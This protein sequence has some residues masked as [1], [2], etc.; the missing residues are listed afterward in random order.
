MLEANRK[1]GVQ[2]TRGQRKAYGVRLHA[3]GMS[4]NCSNDRFLLFSINMKKIDPRVARTRK[5]LHHAL[6]CLG[7]KRGYENLTVRAVT[8]YAGV[9]HVTFYRHYK[10][11]DDLLLE[12]VKTSLADLIGLIRKQDTV[13][14]EM[15]ATFTYIK[16]HQ[17]QFHAFIEL[18]LTHPARDLFKE[19]MGNFIVERYEAQDPTRVPLAVT[20]NHLLE[21][22][23]DM[24]RW[25]LNYIDD[26]TPQQVAVMHIDLIVKAAESTTVVLREDWLEQHPTR[27]SDRGVPA[28][29]PNPDTLN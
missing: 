8:A 14:D 9:S 2:Y 15:M 18:P 21:S 11:L 10:S 7:P 24:L 26:Y 29:E 5:A 3:R 17:Q 12:I 19:E 27:Q 22:T 6:I 23:Y 13:F 4:A 16:E 25:Y 1:H 20:V 28:D